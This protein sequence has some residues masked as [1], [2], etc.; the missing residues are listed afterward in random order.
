MRDE[1]AV[2]FDECEA[3]FGSHKKLGER[4]ESGSN[5]DNVIAGLNVEQ[6]DGRTSQILV[7][8][9]VLAKAAGGVGFQFRKQSLD[10]AQCH[11]ALITFFPF[12]HKDDVN[13]PLGTV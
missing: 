4:A 6:R 3:R 9:K 10:V 13:N 11:G 1:A 8:E 7:V 2:F 12:I 5:F